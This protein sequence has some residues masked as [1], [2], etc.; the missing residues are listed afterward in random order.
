MRDDFW[1]VQL[2]PRWPTVLW[3][4]PR[5]TTCTP[6]ASACET[7]WGH[8]EWI[9]SKK[10]NRM[11]HTLCERLLRAHANLVYVEHATDPWWSTDW[12]VDMLIEEPEE[13]QPADEEEED[14]EV[15]FDL[16]ANTN[17]P[18]AEDTE[19]EPATV[20]VAHEPRRSG[21]ARQTPGGLGGMIGL[22]NAFL[23]GRG[24]QLPAAGRPA[25]Q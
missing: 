6:S 10:R 24:G 23:A 25:A 11:S 15:D 17:T 19:V 9:H 13:P 5:L 18:A 12:E 14:R 2:A 20:E 7:L 16:T 22:V 8:M 3:S 21:R 1:Y 4:G